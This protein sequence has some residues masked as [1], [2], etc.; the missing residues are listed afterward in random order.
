MFAVDVKNI[1]AKEFKLE[2][3][4][5]FP[6]TGMLIYIFSTVFICYLSLYQII[7]VKTWNALF[8]ILSLFAAVNAV[9]KSFMQES[10]GISLYYYTFIDPRALIVAKVI[11]NMLLLTVLSLLTFLIYTL[12]IGNL[13][14]DIA[15]FLLC[16]VLGSCGLSAILTIVSAI[17]ARSNNSSAL[18]AILGF[19]LLFP[20]LITIL[21]FSKNIIDGIPWYVS[22]KYALVLAAIN[23]I[24][25]TLG[26]ILF[27]YLWRD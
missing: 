5:K 17:A 9:A 7:D 27:P 8:W 26:Y 11:Y 20:L 16:I 25:I 10:A 6:F 1:L 24:T 14:T 3:T 19:P 4:Q 22:Y 2:F 15:M 21:K 12:L 18:M 23:L 13:V